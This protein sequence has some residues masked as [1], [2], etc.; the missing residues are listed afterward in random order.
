PLG[1]GP[2]GSIGPVG[3]QNPQSPRGVSPFGRPLTG[4]V[5]PD[6]WNTLLANNQEIAQQITDIFLFKYGMIPGGQQTLVSL[7]NKMVN[8]GYTMEAIQQLID[9]GYNQDDVFREAADAVQLEYGPQE[10]AIRRAIEE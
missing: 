7:V 4:P 8:E 6:Q 3:V 9:Q 5:P 10:A 1:S 2:T